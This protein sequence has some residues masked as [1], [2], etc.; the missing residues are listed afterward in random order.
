M[1]LSK[2]AA[3]PTLLSKSPR[4]NRKPESLYDH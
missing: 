1:A 4:P 2:F 3:A